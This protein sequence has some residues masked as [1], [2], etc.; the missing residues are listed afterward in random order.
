MVKKVFGKKLSRERATREALFVSLVESLVIN[1]KIN[2]TRAKAKAV[3]GLIDRLIS[4]AKK[5]T[6]ASKRQ[7]LK[8]LKGNKKIA[9][10]IWTEVVNYFPER[11][12]G[13]TRIIPI[14]Q[15]KGD[16]AKMVRLEWTEVKLKKEEPKKEDLKTKKDKKVK[17][18]EDKKVNKKT[19]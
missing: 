18:G 13:F 10:I 4:L 7:I 3:I 12:S 14:S 1:K 5:G 6:L 16:L 17:K 2:T 15:R 19:K 11:N 9:T 8:R